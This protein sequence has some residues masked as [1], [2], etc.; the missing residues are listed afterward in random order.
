M[1]KIIRKAFSKMI[2]EKR[3]ENGLPIA[4]IARM[5]GMS[6]NGYVQI[7]AGNAAPN[8]DM[9]FDLHEILGFEF[10]D[11]KQQIKQVGKSNGA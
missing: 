3:N 9:L 11:W 1:T 2:R 7:E 4:K 6:E 8:I 5:M 10:S